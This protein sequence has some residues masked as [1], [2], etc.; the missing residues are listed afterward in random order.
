MSGN[1]T[2]TEHLKLDLSHSP[3]LPTNDFYSRR[4]KIKKLSHSESDKSSNA[5]KRATDSES[6]KASQSF[7]N[8]PAPKLDASTVSTGAAVKMSAIKI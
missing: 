5:T 2:D 8:A 6:F 1:D 4:R 7:A 3:L